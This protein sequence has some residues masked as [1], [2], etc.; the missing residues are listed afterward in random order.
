MKTKWT[1]RYILLDDCWSPRPCASAF[2][3]DP[4]GKPNLGLGDSIERMFGKGK[5][6]P[7]AA[8]GPKGN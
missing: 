6:M 4:P 1:Y 7:L 3:I 8:L 2:T 5:E